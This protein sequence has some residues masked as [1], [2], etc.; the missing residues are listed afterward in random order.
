MLVLGEKLGRQEA[1]EI[2]LE[3]CM[4]S[5]EQRVPLKELLLA[6]PRI[7]KHLT[8]DQLDAL[9]DPTKYTGLA[10]Q[11]VDRVVAGQPQFLGATP[12]ARR[13]TSTATKC[14]EGTRQRCPPMQAARPARVTVLAAGVTTRRQVRGHHVSAGT[15]HRPDVI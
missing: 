15:A 10:S 2:V 14:G 5:F 11:F 4:E 3:V 6:D 9:L 13:L 8:A 1:H 7:A 12:A